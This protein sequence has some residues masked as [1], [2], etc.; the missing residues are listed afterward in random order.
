MRMG[1]KGQL[2][3]DPGMPTPPVAAEEIVQVNPLPQSRSITIFLLDVVVRHVITSIA[4]D[5]HSQRRSTTAIWRKISLANLV[6]TPS[7]VGIYC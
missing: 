4:L 3:K 5:Y 1:Q 2:I 6:E 7:F